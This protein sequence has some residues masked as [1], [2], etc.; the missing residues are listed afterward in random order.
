MGK[1]Y[2]DGERELQNNAS[3]ELCDLSHGAVAYRKAVGTRH[4]S[5]K[6]T[7]ETH[8]TGFISALSRTSVYVQINTH[9]KG[10]AIKHCS[11]TD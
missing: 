9:A 5:Q 1:R 10:C 6:C 4:V 8:L 2:S 7:T 11:L 3:Q